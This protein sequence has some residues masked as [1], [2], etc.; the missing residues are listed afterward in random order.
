MSDGDEQAMISMIIATRVMKPG[1][2]RIGRVGHI[3]LPRTVTTVSLVGF[4]VGAFVG[5]IFG[6]IIGG[7]LRPILFGIGLGGAAGVAAVNYSP[8]QGE[9]LAKWLGLTIRARRGQMEVYGRTTRLAIGICPVSRSA[10]GDARI[11]RGAL[12]VPPSQYDERGVMI[13]KRNHNLHRAPVSA[14]LADLL[15]GHSTPIQ[16][17]GQAPNPRPGRSPAPPSTRASHWPRR[18]S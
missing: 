17:I 11:L 16:V 2:Q 6:L 13:A 8:L 3:Q 1:R 15:E 9:S 5:V 7:S 18:Q 4:M 10:I 12:T 14:V